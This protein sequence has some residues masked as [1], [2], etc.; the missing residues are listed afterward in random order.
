MPDQR[1]AR[2]ASH[3]RET[4]FAHDIRLE[5]RAHAVTPRAFATKGSNMTL[6]IHKS[7]AF[8]EPERELASERQAGSRTSQGCKVK[9]LGVRLFE[10]TSRAEL[11]QELTRAEI[12]GDISEFYALVMRAIVS[13]IEDQ[14][15]EDVISYLDMAGAV[16]STAHE[17]AMVGDMRSSYDSLPARPQAAARQCLVW[18]ERLA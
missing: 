1:P 7:D 12:A 2:R 15:P 4:P 14:D 8:C 16:A 9:Q 17:R 10:A 11:Y 18:V 13:M 5:L 3:A 6:T